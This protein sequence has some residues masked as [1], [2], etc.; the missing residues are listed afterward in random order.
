MTPRTSAR[1]ALFNARFPWGERDTSLLYIRLR[2]KAKTAED[3]R[4]AALERVDYLLRTHAPPVV[5]NRCDW[6][7]FLAAF[8][9]SAID[10]AR[11]AWA[12]N[13]ALPAGPDPPHP[14]GVVT[15][16]LPPD[17]QFWADCVREFEWRAAKVVAKNPKQSCFILAIGQGTKDGS[18]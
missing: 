7:T 5:Y 3:K 10:T 11:W 2:S 18:H 15:T 6:N 14:W 9:A 8:P 4:S 12:L 1:D 16:K 13:Q 17:P